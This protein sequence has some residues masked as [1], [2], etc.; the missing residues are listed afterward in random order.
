VSAAPEYPAHVPRLSLL[1]AVAIALVGVLLPGPS[2]PTVA[3]A[4]PVGVGQI[5]AGS[6]DRASIHLEARYDV[7]LRLNWGTRAVRVS[8]TATI[9]NTSG[10]P[11]DRIELN[12]AA[13]RLGGLSILGAKVDGISVTAT[14]KDQ[15]IT[16][17]LGGILPAGATTKVYLKYGARLRS[18]LSG[19]SDWM[20]TKAN[21]IVDMYR[22][23]PWISAPR[24][25]TR[26]SH[27]DPFVTPTS[28]YVRV[29]I[30]SDR[31]LVYATSGDRV[32][33]DGLEQ[34]FEARNVRDFTVTAAPDFRTSSTKVGSITVIG[35]A[36]T[37]AMATKLRDEGARALSKLQPLLGSY[38]YGS[39]RVAQSAGGYA[40]ESPRLSWIPYGVASSR[41][42]YLVTHETAHQWFYGLVGSDQA[43]EPFTDEAAADF[44]TRYVLGTKR[45]SSCATARLD[46]TIYDYS[47]ACYYEIIYI[48]GG[49]LLDATRKKMGSTAF[50]TALRSYVAEHR[51]RL[52]PTKTL[53]DWLDDATSQDLSQT[54]APRFPR[55]Y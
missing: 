31:K 6:V 11:I 44:V 55:L 40:M 49:N 18:G 17:P 10:G 21:G 16:V 53:L 41:L 1:V 32:K 14:V 27:G 9:R 34:T 28:P 43:R 54:F 37:S 13:A 33:V 2:V 26:A 7:G 39:Y 23:L 47:K 46:R 19:S 4:S 38:P 51:H 3:A 30:V 42:R 24:A 5:V 35:Y 29:R 15:T 36:R 50:W 20:F 12:T 48:Q 25:F 52:A 45:S 22:W 8:S